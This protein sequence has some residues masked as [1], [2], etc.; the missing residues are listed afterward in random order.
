MCA[1]LPERALAYRSLFIAPIVH[2]AIAN[3][4]ARTP[5]RLRRREPPRA[6]AS[7]RESPQ[8]ALRTLRS[9]RAQQLLHLTLRQLTIPPLTY[10]Y[11]Y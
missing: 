9:A 8:V 5:H 3:P 6:A 1:S 11:Y 7:R 4:E 10:I 2:D